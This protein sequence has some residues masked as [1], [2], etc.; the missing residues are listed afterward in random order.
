[1][2]YDLVIVGAGVS[3]I[4]T[5]LSSLE[6]NPQIKV[7]IL[8]AGPSLSERKNS[9]ISSGFGGLGIS[10]G[11][12]NLSTKF[13]G[14]LEDKLGKR[15][16][17]AYLKRLEVY[18]D[19]FGGE[20][21]PY[22]ETKVY[23]PKGTSQITFLENRTKHLGRSLSRML[24]ENIYNY[25]E[26]KVDFYF[27]SELKDI[28]KISDIFKVKT[29]KST[30]LTRKLVIATGNNSELVD[31][32]RKKFSLELGL[33][34]VD[35]GLRIE[36]SEEQLEEILAENMEVKMFYKDYYTYCMNKFGNV[37]SKF[38]DDYHLADGQNY[39][40]A[41]KSDKLN[42]CLFKPYYFSNYRDR[43]K[44]LDLMMR[45]I[46]SSP[47]KLVGSLLGEFDKSYKVKKYLSPS[48]DYQEVNLADYLPDDYLKGAGEF[49]RELNKLLDKNLDG[50]THLY[51]LDMKIYGQS[52]K[53]NEKLQ[54][55][56]KDLYFVGD[57]SGVSS[58]LSHAG[59]SGIYL[60]DILEFEI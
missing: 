22:Y 40:E 21:S 10:E 26:K 60:G 12:Y 27:M 32:L 53:T 41:E 16:A 19:R 58:S 59:A 2:L 44:Y 39:L 15:N 20:A 37:I 34:R 43:K 50:Y 14:N 9:H 25:L 46:N 7:C 17:E 23:E 5:A 57:C 38:L 42:F 33:A 24:Y 48:L 13:G 36:M 1:M 31:I 47:S 45:K 54:S 11:K 30:F 8:E 18:L 28:D 35:F 29:N 49:F 52:I 55:K 51:A 56:I 4:F 6:K 3:G